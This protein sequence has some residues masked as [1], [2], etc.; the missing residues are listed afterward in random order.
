MADLFDLELQD[1]I[2]GASA[3][4][5]AP[6]ITNNGGGITCGILGASLIQ[7]NMSTSH[8]SPPPSMTPN[9]QASS[10]SS[11]RSRSNPGSDYDDDIL[12]QTNCFEDQAPSIYDDAVSDLV[13]NSSDPV[14]GEDSMVFE[15]VHICEETV[16]PAHSLRT[17]TQ[18]FEL[19][20]VLGKG[21]YGK[22]FQVK[23]GTGADQGKIFA[24]KVL[25][26]A[27]IVINQKDTAH[28]K[29][30]RNIL[31]S[32]KHP[33]I[34]DL[35]YAFQ[36]GGKLYLILEYLP[37]GE[38]FMHLEREGIF[39]EE[40]AC[41]YL[42][43]ITLALEHLHS[44][45]IVYRDLKPENILLDK[46]GHVKLTDFGLCKESLEDGETTH[47]FCG[48]VEYMAPEVLLRSGHAKSVDWWSLGALMFDMLTGGPPFTA[49]TRKKT[50]EKILHSK[51]M[52][53]NYLSPE[54]RDLIKKL[55]RRQA[56]QRLGFGAEDGLLIRRH[57]FFR[58]CNW[59]DLIH[60]RVRPPFKPTLKSDD[61]V[62]Q[63]DT[64][65]TRMTP[66]DSP[67]ET[68]LSDSAN[69]V[70]NGFTYVAPS[71][72]NEVIQNN[73]GTHC[74]K[75]SAKRYSLSPKVRCRSPK[76]QFGFF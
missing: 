41:F 31:E 64:E 54:S 33:F 57:Q 72:L 45:G 14:I 56:T 76:K 70:F 34:V 22:V 11:Q 62:S 27:K 32:I 1:C 30:E 74:S 20:R 50:I 67:D 71:I 26:K 25:R 66:V 19:L 47:T 60:K 24:M 29:A 48:T 73:R 44:C 65:F 49:S 21:G 7:D 42:A 59:N 4:T 55:L 52:L 38:L 3:P 13:I 68:I 39:S 36:T 15:Q 40:T 9:A 51:L 28:T 12:D 8:P 16:N 58:S 43:E 35:I 53:P 2:N 6:Q 23:K 63:F 17:G 37:G 61:D 18:D 46:D 5:T 10:G 69:Q 75:C